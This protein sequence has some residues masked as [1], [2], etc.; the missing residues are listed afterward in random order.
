MSAI[1]GLLLAGLLAGGGADGK[2]ALERLKSL[3][4]TWRGHVVT[5]DGPAASVVY[6]VTAGGSTVQEKLFPGTD[7]EMVTMYHL[8][9]NDLVLTHYCAMGN[10]PRMRLVTATGTDPLELRFDF[11]G[12]ANV[13]PARDAHMHAGNITLRGRDRLEAVWAVYDKG[14]QAGANKFYLERVKAEAPRR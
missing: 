9:G 11:A 2:A 14:K 10:Q 3:A 7:H 6:S 8:D 5:P 13:D 12:G 4:G 1:G